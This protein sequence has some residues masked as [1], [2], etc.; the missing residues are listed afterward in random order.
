[1]VKKFTN[2]ND[3]RNQRANDG[4]NSNRQNRLQNSLNQNVPADRFQKHAVSVALVVRR[5]QIVHD[6]H[7]D[8]ED[9]S[10][11]RNPQRRGQRETK[12]RQTDA[13]AEQR[14]NEENQQRAEKSFDEIIPDAI[15]MPRHSLPDESRVGFGLEMCPRF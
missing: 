3:S 5:I 6:H 4:S 7:V 10:D 12:T 9:R 13:D 1:M 14:E 8:V 11:A 15:E 2:Q